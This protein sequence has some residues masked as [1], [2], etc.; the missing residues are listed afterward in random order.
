MKIDSVNIV[1]FF[2]RIKHFQ[3]FEPDDTLTMDG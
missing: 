1:K 3:S 2:P